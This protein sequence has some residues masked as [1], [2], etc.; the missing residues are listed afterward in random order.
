M[1]DVLQKFTAQMSHA[2]DLDSMVICAARL[3]EL[4]GNS[5]AACLGNRVM[6]EQK[7]TDSLPGELPMPWE[8][9]ELLGVLKACMFEASI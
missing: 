8:V 1:H 6:S 4:M 9:I 3:D 2:A 5:N 7:L